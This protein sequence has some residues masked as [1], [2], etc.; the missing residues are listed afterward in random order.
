MIF[1]DS[2]GWI[3]SALDLDDVLHLKTEKTREY[4]LTVIEDKYCEGMKYGRM[5]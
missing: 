1:S 5:V 3:V 2:N 4:F